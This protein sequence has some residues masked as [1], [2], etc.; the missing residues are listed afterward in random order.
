MTDDPPKPRDRPD[1]FAPLPLADL[2]PVRRRGPPEAAAPPAPAAPAPAAPPARSRGV[3]EAP[4]TPATPLPPAPRPPPRDTRPPPTPD[5]RPP[6]PDTRPPPTPE[7]LAAAAPSPAVAPRDASSSTDQAT[8]GSPHPGAS[9]S[10][11]S[12]A[13]GASSWTDMPAPGVPPSAG[14]AGTQPSE[15]SGSMSWTDMPGPL[16]SGQPMSG[17]PDT[18][19]EAPLLPSTYNENDLRAAVGA[20]QLSE[21]VVGAS[22]K[23]SRRRAPTGGDD[24]G[25]GDDDGGRPGKPRSRK[26]MLVGALTLAV[27]G[28]IAAMVIVG[29][30]NSQRYLITCEADRVV[31][32]RGRAFPP[33]GESSLEGAEWRALKIPPEA[34]CAAYE[35]DDTAELAARYLDMLQDHATTLLTAREVT[36]IDEAEAQLKQALLVARSLGR[37]DQRID[38]REEIERLLGDVVYWRASAKLRTAAEALT[39]AANQFELAAKQRPRHVTDAAAW[40]LYVRKLVDQLRTG[41]AGAAQAAFP[42]L[43][44]GE[45]PTVPPGVALPVE[46]GT[47]S[48]S[49]ASETD[50]APPAADAGLPTGG[51][52]L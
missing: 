19:T 37:D 43:L 4:P 27:G 47:G 16:S 49:A 12:E 17:A 41:P 39:E 20:T 1:P 40:A 33:W 8:L 22:G 44:P 14:V 11:S 38:A 24:I 26:L 35:T 51:V 32:E 5:T 34:P 9:K 25:G 46:P 7:K 36:K 10:R 52:L 50:P 21:S 6:T 23:K 42:P 3:S 13:A 31:V 15:G 18:A 29:K 45:G 48:E 28:A 2:P 30:I